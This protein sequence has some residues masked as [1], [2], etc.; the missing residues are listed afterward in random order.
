[1]GGPDGTAATIAV[2]AGPCS[3][4]TMSEEGRLPEMHTTVADAQDETPCTG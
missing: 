3:L 2:T 4:G 1:M